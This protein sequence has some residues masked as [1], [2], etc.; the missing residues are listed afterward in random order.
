MIDAMLT[1]TFSPTRDAILV[2]SNANGDPAT[3]LDGSPGIAASLATFDGLD[4]QCGDQLLACGDG[5]AGCYAT[6]ADLLALDVLWVK[7]D[8]SGGCAEFLAV[9]LDAKGLLGNDMCGGRTPSMDVVGRMYSIAIIG[10]LSG[11]DDSVSAPPQANVAT[12]PYLA[13]AD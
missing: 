5:Q 2:A 3:W 7:G 12:F 4:T 9:E 11:F 10:E 6:L 1:G 13:P 8:A